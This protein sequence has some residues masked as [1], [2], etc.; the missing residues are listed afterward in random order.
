MIC[1]KFSDADGNSEGAVDA[2]GPTREMFRL[3]LDYLRT[4]TLFTAV[5]SNNWNLTVT[6]NR[7]AIEKRHYFYAG[8]IIA[9]SIV[10]GGPGPHF[11]SE[12]LF[13]IIVE[14]PEFVNPVEDDI[15]SEVRDVLKTLQNYTSL[16]EMQEYINTQEY[17]SVAGCQQIVCTEECKNIVQCM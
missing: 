11:F 7:N 14:G 3:L 10:H 6:L 9:L 17:F 1:V 13:N 4:S 16:Q 8:Q 15:G 12:L 2:G 5:N